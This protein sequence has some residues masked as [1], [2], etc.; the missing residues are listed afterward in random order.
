M[1]FNKFT[2]SLCLVL[3]SSFLVAEDSLAM[4]RGCKTKT[5]IQSNGERNRIVCCR[6]PPDR[7]A[8]LERLVELGQA[9]A[10]QRRQ[11][12]NHYKVVRQLRSNPTH[13]INRGIEINKVK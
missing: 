7:V 13:N 10:Y 1:N 3:S 9:T 5:C 2:S 11:L 8:K 12:A 4:T 6:L